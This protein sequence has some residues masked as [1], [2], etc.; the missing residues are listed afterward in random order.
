MT[1]RHSS[2]LLPQVTGGTS[3]AI[4]VTI[5]ARELT[6]SSFTANYGLEYWIVCPGLAPQG[7]TVQQKA[8][9]VPDI[10]IAKTLA[11]AA[12]VQSGIE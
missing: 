2:A 5:P 12:K 8:S 9:V 3:I 6:I 7:K 1:N 10:V 11:E 4:R